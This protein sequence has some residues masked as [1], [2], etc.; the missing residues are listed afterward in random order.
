MREEFVSK[1]GFEP[2]ISNFTHCISIIE[3]LRHR[4]QLRIKTSS[5]TS[6][7]DSQNVM[8]AFT[9]QREQVN[10]WVFRRAYFYILTRL[11]SFILQLHINFVYQLIVFMINIERKISV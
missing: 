3:P 1:L 8:H 10:K 7:Q 9:N 2:Q 6:T 11:T 5:H 4:Y